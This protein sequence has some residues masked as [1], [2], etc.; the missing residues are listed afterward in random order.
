MFTIFVARF[1]L[2]AVA[3][4]HS[5]TRFR[6]KQAAALQGP[7]S[8]PPSAGLF[9]WNGRPTFGDSTYFLESSST[10]PS[11]LRVMP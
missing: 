5:P 2:A 1:A 3:A 8:T 4:S 9:Y 10:R 7:I 11:S 6:V